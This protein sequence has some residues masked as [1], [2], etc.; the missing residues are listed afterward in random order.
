[1]NKVYLVVTE[2]SSWDDYMWNI[3]CIC[4]TKEKAEEKEKI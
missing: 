2:Q 4:Y 1:M 3:H